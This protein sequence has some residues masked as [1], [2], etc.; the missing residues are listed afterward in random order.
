MESKENL[1]DTWG[2]VKPYMDQPDCV[3]DLRACCERCSEYSKESNPQE[4]CELRESCPTFQLWLSYES[5]HYKLGW[6]GS[7]SCS[8]GENTTG[9][10]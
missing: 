4:W 5:V 2:R 9:W 10:I 8:M 6:S 7:S 3:K 1:K